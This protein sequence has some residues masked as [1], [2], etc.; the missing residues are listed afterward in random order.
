MRGILDM[1]KS[2]LIGGVLFLLPLIVVIVVVE[3]AV[4]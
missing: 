4:S 3:K 2:T 1:A